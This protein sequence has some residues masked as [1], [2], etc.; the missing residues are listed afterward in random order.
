MIPRYYNNLES[1]ITPGKVLVIYGPRRVGKTTLLEGYLANTSYQ[2][3][4]LTGEDIN[5]K[6]VLG[7]QDLASI[8]RFV[9]GYD[10]VAIDEAQDIQNIG[11]GL[12]LLIDHKPDL[13]VIVTGSS[14]FDIG[15]NVGEPLTGRKT[16]LNLYPVAQMELLDSQNRYELQQNL[17]DYLIYGTYPGTLNASTYENKKKYLTELTGSYLLKDILALDKVKSS[18]KLVSLLQLLA[19]QVG[20]QVSNEELANNLKLNSR[21][22]ERYLDLLEQCFIVVRLGGFSRNLRSEVTRKSKY[23]FLD[24]GVRNALLQQFN[25]LNL[26][27]DVGFLWENFLVMERLKYRTYTN[28]YGNSYFWRTYGQQEIDLIEDYDGKLHGYEFKWSSTKTPKAPGEWATAYP[29]ATY[30]VINQDN[31]LDFVVGA[32]K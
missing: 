31:Y 19:L 12:K 15:R 6:Q 10:L 3:L 24:N 16:T 30:E 20:N 14:S 22:V 1:Y 21:T 27:S 9:E 4:L 2:Y 32:G 29:D 25:S 18:R 11:M 13:R 28:K 7:S 26:R 23:Y 17:E 8:L 5:T